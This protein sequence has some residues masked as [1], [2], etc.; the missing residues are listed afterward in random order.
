M[1]REG[2]KLKTSQA[3]AY[4]RKLAFGVGKGTYDAITKAVNA[5]ADR[6]H[7]A[8]EDEIEAAAEAK[9]QRKMQRNLKNIGKA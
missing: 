6:A 9:R 3:M 7:A 4:M 5:R 1:K 8:V 2:N